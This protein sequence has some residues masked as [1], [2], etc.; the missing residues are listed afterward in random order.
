[1]ASKSIA[2]SAFGLMSLIDSE[3]IWAWGIIVNNFNSICP[4]GSDLPR[5]CKICMLQGSKMGQKDILNNFTEKETEF[6]LGFFTAYSVHHFLKCKLKWR[7]SRIFRS[8]HHWSSSGKFL[9]NTSWEPY[10]SVWHYLLKVWHFSEISW[11]VTYS[12]RCLLVRDCSAL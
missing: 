12:D 8:S 5:K 4:L 6:W 2:Y 10:R 7:K 1:M 3:S 9:T 11:T